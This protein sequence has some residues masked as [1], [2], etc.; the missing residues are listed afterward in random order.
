[1]SK[2]V[3]SNPAQNLTLTPDAARNITGLKTSIKESHESG[4][5]AYL[6]NLSSTHTITLKHNS[7]SSDANNRFQIH[8][9]ADLALLP[10][11]KAELWFSTDPARTGWVIG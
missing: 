10:G 6:F 8:G 3:T 1:M 2:V 7:G 4:M 11:A 5:N 9:D